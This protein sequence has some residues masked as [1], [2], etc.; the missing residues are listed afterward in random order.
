MRIVDVFTKKV[1]II[2]LSF[3]IM[4]III[5]ILYLDL[6]E[7]QSLKNLFSISFFI[8]VFHFLTCIFLESEFD[9][10]FLRI[11]QIKLEKY[12]SFISL[13]AAI[14][15]AINVNSGI[16]IYGECHIK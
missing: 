7:I 14:S 8:I 5:F 3:I 13:I 16:Y 10:N 1:Y 15:G 11:F 2:G 12:I 9:Y 6:S 4:D